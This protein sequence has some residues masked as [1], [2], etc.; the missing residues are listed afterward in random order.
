MSGIPSASWGGA[1]RRASCASSSESSRRRD[2][3]AIVA[4]LFVLA[5]FA[6][7]R[8]VV[9]PVDAEHVLLEGRAA[10]G[11]PQAILLVRRGELLR[12]LRRLDADHIRV[13]KLAPNLDA[14]VRTV[15]AARSAAGLVAVAAG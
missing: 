4:A 12:R 5:V 9:I 2:D 8:R 15:A 3:G 11:L 6:A 13:G 7:R 10:A 1:G 14:R